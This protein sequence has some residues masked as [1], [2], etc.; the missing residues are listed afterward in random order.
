[1]HLRREAITAEEIVIIMAVMAETII[2]ATIMNF[3]MM[4]CCK[5]L[6]DV[7]ALT[8]RRLRLNMKVCIEDFD[9]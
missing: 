2:C 9:L 3:M 7:A 8:R 4:R 6:F 5:Y 1:M